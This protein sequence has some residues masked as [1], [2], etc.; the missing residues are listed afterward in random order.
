MLSAKE[1]NAITIDLTEHGAG[2]PN[3]VRVA[4]DNVEM[5]G[6]VF[7]SAKDITDALVEYRRRTSERD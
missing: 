6:R 5:T 3:E 1:R 4:N 7:R 2:R